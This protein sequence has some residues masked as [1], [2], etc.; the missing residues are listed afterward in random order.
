MRSGPSPI[1]Q[2]RELIDRVLQDVDSHRAQLT[3]MADD[4]P[5]PRRQLGDDGDAVVRQRPVEVLSDA[6]ASSFTWIGCCLP[7]GS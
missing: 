4:G 3:L 7:A 2:R 6:R 1:G 5:K